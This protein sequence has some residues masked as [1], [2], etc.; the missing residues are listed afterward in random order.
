VEAFERAVT[1]AI[2]SEPEKRVGIRRGPFS[3]RSAS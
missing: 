1:D 3:A 2:D